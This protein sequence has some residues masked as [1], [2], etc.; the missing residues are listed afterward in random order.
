MSRKITNV[1]AIMA[2]LALTAGVAKAQNLVWKIN[3]A[4]SFAQLSI[5]TTFI[6]ASV[7]GGLGDLHLSQ[8][9][10]G[11]APGGG[12]TDGNAGPLSGTFSTNYVEGTSVQFTGAN[13][14][15]IDHVTAGHPTGFVPN[16]ALWDPGSSSYIAIS[17][18][19]PAMWASNTY[20]SELASNVAQSAFQNTHFDLNSASPV[21]SSEVA[22]NTEVFDPAT[23]NFGLSQTDFLLHTLQPALVSDALA[24]GVDPNANPDGHGSDGFPLPAFIGP[25]QSVS[26]LS[27]PAVITAAATPVP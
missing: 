21:P 10:Q 13:I 14:L 2:V 6:P 19:A 1:M 22:Y 3:P 4:A 15:G 20:V 18:Q 5:Q 11:G 7:S 25:N 23:S 12:W 27:A 9:T 26:V 16:A 8:I 24:L 17:P